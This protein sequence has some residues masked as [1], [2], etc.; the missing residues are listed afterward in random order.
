MGLFLAMR[1]F[2]ELEEVV[3]ARLWVKLWNGIGVAGWFLV[4]EKIGVLEI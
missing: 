3:E 1:M 4:L 2:W